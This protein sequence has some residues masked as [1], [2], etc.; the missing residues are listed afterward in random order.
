MV[1]GQLE[2]E[3]QRSVPTASEGGKKRHVPC[4]S[5]HSIRNAVEDPLEIPLQLEAPGRKQGES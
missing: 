3:D 2:K 4:T 1:G 5:H